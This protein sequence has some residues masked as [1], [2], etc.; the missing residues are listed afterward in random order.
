[1]TR[2]Y[3][4]RHG[5]T[6]WNLERRY[7]GQRESALTDFG[8]EQMRRLAA[9]LAAEPVRAVY[10]SPLQRCRWSAE[11]I[12]AHHGL[13]PVVEPNLI[14]LNHGLL[15]GLRI[16]EMEEHLGEVVR[17]W[18]RDPANVVIPQGEPLASARDRAYAAFRRILASHPNETVVVVAH[19]GVN[20]L[21]LLTLLGAPLDSYFR[22]QQHNGAI[23]LVEYRDDVGVRVVAINDTCYLKLPSTDPAVIGQE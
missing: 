13:R 2:V 10:T 1:M 3:L 14:E 5:Q 20:K 17:R 22:L 16:D 8:R 15:D 9:A 23:N 7:Q 18:W 6:V 19:G 11:R 12:A 4:V 21:I